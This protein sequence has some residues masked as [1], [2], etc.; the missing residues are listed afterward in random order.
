M[1]KAEYKDNQCIK[2][3]NYAVLAML[4]V[5]CVLFFVFSYF[6]VMGFKH[7]GDSSSM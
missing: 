3:P 1:L 2:S 5:S 7:K 6:L 4:V